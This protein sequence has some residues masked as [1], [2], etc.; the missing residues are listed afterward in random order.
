MPVWRNAAYLLVRQDIPD[1]SIPDE[2][3]PI[4]RVD[5]NGVAVRIVRRYDGEAAV[6]QTDELLHVGGLR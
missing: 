3:P 6:E 5:D 1:L 4:T 2:G